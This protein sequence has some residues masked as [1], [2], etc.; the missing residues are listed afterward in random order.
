MASLAGTQIKNTYT[1]LLKTT[2]NDAIT[3]SLKRITDGAGASTAIQL[4]SSQLKA[5]ALLIENVSETNTLTRFL[6]WDDTAKTVGYYNFSQSDPA[7]S[8]SSTATNATVTTGTNASNTFTIEAGTNVGVSTSGN[9]ITI[10]STAS[11]QNVS[12][13]TSSITDGGRHTITDTSGTAHNIDI[14]GTNGVSVSFAPSTGKYTLSRSESAT[15]STVGIST[16]GGGIYDLSESNSGKVVYIN[17]NDVRI[18]L[19][20]ASAGLNYK[21]FFGTNTSATSTVKIQCAGSA[22]FEGRLYHFNSHFEKE[23]VAFHVGASVA[24]G[25]N[26]MNFSRVAA[27][28]GFI[29]D[30]IEIIAR[31]SSKWLV[32]GHVSTDGS[33]STY[34]AEYPNRPAYL[35]DVKTTIF[36]LTSA[37]GGPG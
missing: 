23:P 9:T 11:T 12:V 10:S 4:S 14:V 15:I 28:G 31:D 36:S 32:N 26:T 33:W 6:T 24:D 17:T 16:G 1:G 8:V 34:E 13:T 30:S 35:T 19:P 7:V 29:G 5:D 22:V 20:N 21:F 27:S 18:I 37:G 25:Y 2:A 3:S